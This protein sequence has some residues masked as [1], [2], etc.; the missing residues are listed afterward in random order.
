MITL[1]QAQA[2][3]DLMGQVSTQSRIEWVLDDV[4]RCGEIRKIVP[5]GDNF[6]DAHVWVSTGGTEI[7]LPVSTVMQL[8]A[9][10][11]WVPV[12]TNRSR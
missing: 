7:S 8:I 9:N 4:E 1:S 3:S 12:P 6:L 2:I 10:H 5:N 11:E